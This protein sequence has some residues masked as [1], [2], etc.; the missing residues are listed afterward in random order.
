MQLF[1][2]RHGVA[3]DENASRGDAERRLTEEGKKKVRQVLENASEAGMD[4]T[5]IVSSPLVRAVQTAEIARDLLKHKG[6][7]LRT[8]SLL[9]GA[10]PEQVWDEIRVHRDE[11]G[12]LLVGHNPLFGYLPGFLLGSKD[13]EIDFK[14]GAI[15]RIDFERISARPSGT[16]R[17]HLTAKLATSRG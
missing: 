17:Y 7:I 6:E 2:L 3:E 4:P 14:K 1:L 15:M 5:L 8:K 10:T 12:I 16:L 9:P 13:L 11:H